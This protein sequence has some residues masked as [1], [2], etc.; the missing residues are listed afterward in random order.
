[1]TLSLYAS[2][3][4]ISIADYTGEK[5][6]WEVTGEAIT[7]T[8]YDG[9]AIEIKPKSVG[10]ATVRA[11]SYDGDTVFGETTVDVTDSKKFYVNISS[12]QNKFPLY[13]SLNAT[14]LNYMGYAVDEYG[15]YVPGV[16]I[17]WTNNNADIYAL[18]AA[19]YKDVDSDIIQY[20]ILSIPDLKETGSVSFSSKISDQ[21]Y[22]HETQTWYFEITETTAR[23]M[24][25]DVLP[26]RV[27]FVDESYKVSA[28]VYDQYGLKTTLPIE[29]S[30]TNLENENLNNNY[31]EVRPSA[32]GSAIIEAKYGGMSIHYDITI[33]TE[34]ISE[35]RISCSSLEIPKDGHRTLDVKL[36]NQNGDRISGDLA[37]SH[38]LTISGG[39]SYLDTTIRGGVNL[40]IL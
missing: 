21:E 29:W 39:E 3:A 15:N 25:F 23:S 9:D 26:N 30:F 13:V 1:M 16:E 8:S 11:S 24:G 12:G 20:Y 19:E 31:Q 17:T 6:N 35:I 33:G 5:I 40:P 10:T 2:H 38:S 7:I 36:L 14:E 28:W 18:S 4:R 32:T 34:E 27:L 37:G 22:Q